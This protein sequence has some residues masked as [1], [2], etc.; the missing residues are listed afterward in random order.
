MKLQYCK[1]LV[2][3]TICLVI[4]LEVLKVVT[5]KSEAFGPACCMDIYMT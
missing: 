3:S 1:Q 5:P 2:T 4:L